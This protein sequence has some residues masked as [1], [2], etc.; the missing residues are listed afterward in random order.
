MTP[1]GPVMLQ[2]PWLAVR[3]RKA[4]AA[5]FAAAFVAGCSYNDEIASA[6]VAPGK[7]ELYN[8]EDLTIRGRDTAKREREL[9]AL[10]E[11]SEKGTGGVLVNV[12]A[13]RTEYLTA[14]GELMQLE[15]AAS[16]KNCASFHSIGERAVR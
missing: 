10:M 8:C 13:Y 9:R 6:I 1:D 3:R 12:L 4:V 2:S 5:V 15:A 11:Q 16:A 14:R 7:Y